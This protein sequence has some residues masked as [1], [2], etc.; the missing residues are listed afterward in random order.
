[1]AFC[2][3]CGATLKSDDARFCA[4]CGRAVSEAPPANRIVGKPEHARSKPPHTLII[5]GALLLVAVVVAQFIAQLPDHHNKEKRASSVTTTSQNATDA[6]SPATQTPTPSAQ[7]GGYSTVPFD[8]SAQVL[9]PG[10]LGHDPERLFRR[11]DFEKLN[12]RDKERET[13]SE[14]RKRVQRSMAKPILGSLKY[15]STYAFEVEPSESVYDTDRQ[16]LQVLVDVEPVWVHSYKFYGSRKSVT[17]KR[18]VK[19]SGAGR[20]TAHRPA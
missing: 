5:F 14:Y 10:Y 3:H 8:I 20:S 1:M 18:I 9:A 16:R 12:D 19:D 15:N 17:V 7:S 11:I 2:I 13:T 6:A 4:V